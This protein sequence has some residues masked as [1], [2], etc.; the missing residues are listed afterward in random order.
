MKLPD[1]SWRKLD[2]REE[3][4]WLWKATVG[5][6]GYGVMG[7]NGKAMR[8]H[9]ISYMLA[10]GEI[11]HGMV[12]MHTFDTPNCVRPDH[13]KLGTRDDNAKDRAKKGRRADCKGRAAGAAF[14]E[15]C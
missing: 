13:L 4:C 8:A 12:V 6:K 7:V 5:N 10:Y 11:P 2:K 3:G 1:R 14:L 15:E 9:R